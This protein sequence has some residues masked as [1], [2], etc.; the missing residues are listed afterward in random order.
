MHFS[1]INHDRYAGTPIA[2]HYTVKELSG[3]PRKYGDFSV[4]NPN[5]KQV[6]EFSRVVGNPAR[7]DRISYASFKDTRILAR[8]RTVLRDSTAKPLADDERYS[9]VAELLGAID[10]E[11][12]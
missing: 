5:C 10:D 9:V 12:T 1:I 4:S 8:V 7:L 3:P 6:R 11:V 2:R